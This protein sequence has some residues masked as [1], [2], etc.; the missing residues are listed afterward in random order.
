[1]ACWKESSYSSYYR[2]LEPEDKVSYKKKL[3]LNSGRLLPDPCSIED[4]KW[5]QD[6][7]LMP[8][9]VYADIVFYLLETPSEYTRD[10]IR[11]Y[12]SLEAWNFFICGHVQDIFI[13]KSKKKTFDFVFFKS[14]VLPSQ[15]QGQRGPI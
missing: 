13:Y 4:E 2:D 11:C 3:T 5:K 14:S 12:K 6:Q 15:R 10:K 7:T 8:D 1:M 9:I